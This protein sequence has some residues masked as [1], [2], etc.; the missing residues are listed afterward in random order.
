VTGQFV[1]DLTS[2]GYQAG[3]AAVRALPEPVVAATF[4]VAADV[5]FRRRGPGV[6]QL[7]RN[8]KRVLGPSATPG[9]LSTVVHAGLHSYARY[10][11]ETFRLPVMDLADVAERA[12]ATTPGLE[13]IDRGMQAGRGVILAL[14]H[15]GN[16]DIAGVSMV[17]RFGG[18]TTVMER[19]R[20]ESLYR[21]FL[22][23]REGIG[24]ETLPLTGG[25]NPM[26]ILRDRLA[27]GGLVC[28]VADRDLSRSGIPVTFF[29]EPT[30]MPP[31]PSML[32]AMTG[33]DL[34]PV[35]LSFTDDGWLHQ[36]GP[37]LALSGDRLA[38]QVQGGT[39]ALAS[40]FEGRIAEHPADWHML[41][42]FWVADRR[43]RADTGVGS[44]AP[45]I[46]ESAP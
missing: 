21:R 34:L 35:H 20:P 23:F 28:L 26:S 4:W 11:M 6:V 16:W 8:L 38:E 31:G 9:E 44:A 42:P 7:A 19:L 36:V 25:S 39:Q 24:F 29:G 46:L 5:A 13:Y 45:P 17:R 40:W 41:Q 22:A 10:W 15:S 32:A 37:P 43:P 27:A 12:L 18:F 14:P 2:L 30:S 1:E 3:W 33:A